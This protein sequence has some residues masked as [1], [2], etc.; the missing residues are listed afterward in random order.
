[1]MGGTIEVQSEVG[2]GTRMILTLPL[3]IADPKDVQDAQSA[4]AAG[5][6]HALLAPARAAPTV[7]AAELEGTLVL[8]ADDHPVNRLLLG[9][10]IRL[11]GYAAEMAENGVEA[12]AKWESGRFGIV[13]T[14]VNM[15]E[16][17]G[18]ELAREIRSREAQAGAA[19]IRRSSRA[20][21]T[22]CAAKRR[23]AS[24][25]AWTTTCRS[26]SQLA[27]LQKKLQQWLPLPAPS[28]RRR[29]RRAAGPQP[30]ATRPSST[31][32]RSPSLQ[33]IRPARRE[34]LS[35]FQHANRNDAVTLTEAVRREAPA[36]H[37]DRRAPHERRE[38]DG[39][40]ESAGRG[41]RARRAG[42]EGRGSGSA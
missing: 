36:R 21:R 28:R 14:D 10:Q 40:P 41:V 27:E 8:V 30:G 7:A 13:V 23:C 2:K 19:D 11:L 22:R 20:P 15:P 33:A 38:Q 4:F 6:A 39:R 35:E 31:G 18:Y 16:M 26:R 9:R 5:V 1:M 17:D 37:Q 34:I 32:P 12:L 29:R 3:P 24:R 25:R 42:G